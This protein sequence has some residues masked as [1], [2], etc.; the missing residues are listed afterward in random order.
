[1]LGNLTT[2]RAALPALRASQG[3]IV[4]MSSFNG[5]LAWASSAPYGVHVTMIE[6]GVFATEFQ[7]SLHVIMPDEVYASTVGKFLGDFS[8]LPRSAFGNPEEV[9]DAVITAATMDEPPLRL[10][11]G[12][13]A[14]AGIRNSLQTRLAELEKTAVAFAGTAA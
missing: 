3:R 12:A 13:D 7:T 14:I 10:P 1:L 6:L 8:Q 4:Q 5:Q 9:A 11:V 2:L